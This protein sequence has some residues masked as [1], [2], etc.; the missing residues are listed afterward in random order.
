MTQ[1]VLAIDDQVHMLKLLERILIEQT[2]YQITALNNSLEAKQLLSKED[3]DLVITDLKMPGFSGLDIL[4]FIKD[5]NRFE[6]VIIIT[7]F[8]SLDS[9]LTAVS[10]GAFDYIIKPFKKD[11]M[12]ISID[13][14]MT[15]Q[16]TKKRLQRLQK[17][18]S[19]VPYSSAAEQFKSEYIEYFLDKH[20]QDAELVSVETGIDIEFVNSILKEKDASLS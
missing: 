11:Q 6:E 5:N 15:L 20:N 4:N 3:F 14:A 18:Y 7:A 19:S 13:R 12:L 16:K 17:V 10:L 9:A 1:K 2:D 8:A